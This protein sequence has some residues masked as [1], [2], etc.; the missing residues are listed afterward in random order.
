M[1][2]ELVHP[3]SEFVKTILNVFDNHKSCLCDDSGKLNGVFSNAEHIAE[4]CK[5]AFGVSLKEEEGRRVCG[6]LFLSP[7]ELR[8]SIL[9]D[10]PL[11][12][13]VEN[14]LP[15]LIASSGSAVIVN[16]NKRKKLEI[17]GLCGRPQ[18]LGCLVEVI[19][20]TTV[21]F[22]I[23]ETEPFAVTA[24]IIDGLD[25][26]TP[27]DAS[28]NRFVEILIHILSPNNTRLRSLEADLFINLIHVM[29]M[30]RHGGTVMIFPQSTIPHDAS[31]NL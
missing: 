23:L 16:E 15:L 27:N 9:F 30:L 12:F 28:L 24:A 1:Q 2:L 5:V 19:R 6:T 21:I 8:H 18:L 14:V 7:N 17:L 26:Y 11:P 22:K 4:I 29:C 10:K 25:L 13:N 20:P 31:H 3:D